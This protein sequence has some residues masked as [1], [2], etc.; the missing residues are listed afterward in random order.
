MNP[1]RTIG[2]LAC[3][4]ATLAAATVAFAAAAPAALTTPRP[5]PP[6]WNKHPPLPAD[7]RLAARYLPGWNKHPPISHVR[8]AA[9]GG[10]PGWQITLVAV[11]V[12]LAAGQ[13]VLLARAARLLAAAA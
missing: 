4:L 5:R 11:T 1:K 12:L 2:H 8:A 10:L 7:P 3:F 13:L 6:G 9:S